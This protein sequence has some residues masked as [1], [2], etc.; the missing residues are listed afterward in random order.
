MLDATIDALVPPWPV[1]NPPAR[2]E[3]SAHCVGF[4]RAQLALAPFHIRTGFGVLFLVFCVYALLRPGLDRARALMAFSALPLP[5]VGGVERLLRA[6]TMLAFFDDPV[7]VA[8]IGEMPADERQRQFR[9]RRE[10][11][12]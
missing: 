10:A 11:L 6:A 2:A 1:L 3:V 4:V 8:A 12:P 5:M 7:V 9:A